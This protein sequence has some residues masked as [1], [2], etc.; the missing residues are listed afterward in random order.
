MF[1]GLIDYKNSLN[2]KMNQNQIDPGTFSMFEPGWW[3]LHAVA[4]TG[5]YMLG[6]RRGKAGGS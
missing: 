3:A 6:N 1:S 4:I 2:K 5:L